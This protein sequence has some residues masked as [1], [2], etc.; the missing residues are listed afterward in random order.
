MA[1]KFAV[2]HSPKARASRALSKP[3]AGARCMASAMTVVL[4]A[5]GR[6]QQLHAAV[7]ARHQ[8][9][10]GR[11]QRHVELARGRARRPPAAVPRSRSAP[12]RRRRS[13]RCCR[14]APPGRRSSGRGAPGRRRWPRRGTPAAAAP[15]RPCNRRPG[16]G[17][18]LARSGAGA[19]MAAALLT[20][21][22]PRSLRTS[23]S[24]RTL[25]RVFF[26]SSARNSIDPRVLVGGQPLPAVGDQLGARQRHRRPQR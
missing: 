25:P 4:H 2:T 20:S 19:V 24:F 5:A 3:K 18:R 22:R 9:A 21:G 10:L 6:V 15:R 11:G 13:S 23:S 7:V 16:A 1:A 12:G 17:S 8:G 14:R 26:G